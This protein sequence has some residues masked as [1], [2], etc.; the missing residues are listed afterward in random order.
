MRLGNWKCELTPN[1]K[2]EKIYN[3]TEILE[4]HRHRYEFNN[5]FY[6]EFVE[7]NFIPVGKNPETELVEI[8]EHNQHPYYIGVQFHPEYKSTVASPHPLFISFIEASLFNKQNDLLNA[9]REK[10]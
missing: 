10:I 3:T 4:R 6:D 5:D 1:S 2:I 8:L 9:T 7:N